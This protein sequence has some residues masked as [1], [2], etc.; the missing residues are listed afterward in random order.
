MCLLKDVKKPHERKRELGV[1]CC[2][3]VCMCVCEVTF[4]SVNRGITE[5]TRCK[6]ASFKMIYSAVICYTL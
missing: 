3:D 4:S 6:S 5:F 1:V 2:F